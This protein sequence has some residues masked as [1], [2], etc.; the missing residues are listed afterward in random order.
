MF[1]DFTIQ[2][3]FTRAKGR[4]EKCGTP[5][6]FQSRGVESGYGWEAHHV[7]SLASNGSNSLSNCKILCV[8][9]HKKTRSYGSA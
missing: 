1:T 6:S 7:I 4:C 2:Q 8:N 5:L 3:A 9:C